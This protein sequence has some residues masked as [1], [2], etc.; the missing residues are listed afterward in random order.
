MSRFLTTQRLVSLAIVESDGTRAT[1]SPLPVT[2]QQIRL[3]LGAVALWWLV[4]QLVTVADEMMTVLVVQV[5][6]VVILLSVIA[7]ELWQS[8][9]NSR[10]GQA[11]TTPSRR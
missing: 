9:S 10:I 7:G 5:E 2:W 3:I 11:S 1:V 8:V 4:C 6:I